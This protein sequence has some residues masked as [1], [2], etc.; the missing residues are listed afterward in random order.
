MTLTACYFGFIDALRA[1]TG[2]SDTVLHIHAGMAILLLARLASGRS[3]GTLL[4]LSMVAVAEFGNEV[5]DRLHFGSWRWPDTLGD[6][7][8]TLFW[9]AVICMAVRV[10][11][12]VASRPDPRRPASVMMA[13]RAAV[14]LFGQARLGLVSQRD[15]SPGR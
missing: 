10:R 9:P 11:P 12:M 4:P 5:M 15:R 2:L 13:G 6:V 8:N 14:A 1:A 3:L 7:A